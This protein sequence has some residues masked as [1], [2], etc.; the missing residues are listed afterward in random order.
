LYQEYA[1]IMGITLNRND[2]KNLFG[3]GADLP[4]YAE[5]VEVVASA[6]ANGSFEE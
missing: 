2:T 6:R 5:I 4:T 3:D 1:D